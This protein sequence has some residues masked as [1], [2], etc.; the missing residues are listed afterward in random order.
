VSEDD[1]DGD[2][3]DD[4]DDKKIAKFIIFNIQDFCFRQ[5]IVRQKITK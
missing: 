2:D 4:D 3:D 1:G 5:E